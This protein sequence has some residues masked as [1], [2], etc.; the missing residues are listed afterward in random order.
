MKVQMSTV[1]VSVAE[2]HGFRTFRSRDIIIQL[3]PKVD[4]VDVSTLSYVVPTKLVVKIQNFHLEKLK[5]F[6]PLLIFF[7]FLLMRR[8]C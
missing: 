8:L 5:Q 1:V 3:V 7:R 2:P 4:V 6:P